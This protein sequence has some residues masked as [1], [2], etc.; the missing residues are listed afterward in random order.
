MSVVEEEREAAAVPDLVV[1]PQKFEPQRAEAE[2]EPLGGSRY[3]SCRGGGGRWFQR[4]AV[5][6]SAVE[7]RRRRSG[8]GGGESLGVDEKCVN[9]GKESVEG[10][11]EPRRCL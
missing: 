8:G 6:W 7:H 1:R 2:Q 10:C 5:G 9:G 11:D 4:L 3:D